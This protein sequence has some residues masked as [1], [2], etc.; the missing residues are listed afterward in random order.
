MNLNRAF[1]IEDLHRVAQRRLPDFAFGYLDGGAEDHKTLAV[2]RQIFERWRFQPDALVN[3]AKPRMLDRDLLGAPCKLP[4]IIAPTGFNG[5]LWH[6][7]DI[8]LARMA[9][10]AGI[11]FCL[12]TMSSAAIEDV[13][14]A[15]EGVNLWFQLYVLK[16]PAITTNL[17]QRARSVDCNTLVVT[18]DS[19]HYGNRETE[20]RPF[21]APLKLSLPS[22][23]G[24]ACHPRW[25]YRVVLPNRGIPGF[26]NL[27]PYLPTDARGRVAGAQFIQS[28]L[29]PSLDWDRLRRMRDNWPGKLIIKGILNAADARHAINCGADGI[30]LTNHGGRQLDGT[31]SPMEVLSEIHA[32]CGGQIEILIDSGFRRGT[33]IT[34]AL[35]LGARGVMLGRA[36]LYGM[37]VA[38]QPGAQH[39]LG[40]LSSEL[41]R[42]LAQLGV[43]GIDELQPR[44]LK[45]ST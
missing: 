2:N 40:I 17:L 37:A 13:A 35:A 3:N 21:R 6:N 19:S 18:T 38:G 1:N 45:S 39:A 41:D 11:P 32:T 28:Q 4:L 30:V 9:R 15:A 23:L 8:L 16:D 26:G 27:D 25:L 24:V 34:K 5:M 43:H 29:D 31:I 14:R 42:T 22:L 10:E 7:A 36:L 20:R 12:S 33:D 44:H